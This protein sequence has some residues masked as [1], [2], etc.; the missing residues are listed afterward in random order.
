MNSKFVYLVGF[1]IEIYHDAQLHERQICVGAIFNA[2]RM[3]NI[4]YPKGNSNFKG[5][6]R[7][8]KMRL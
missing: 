5:N 1:T 8:Y 2:R 4:M 3:N 7:A 6:C